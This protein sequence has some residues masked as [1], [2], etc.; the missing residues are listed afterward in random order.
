MEMSSPWAYEPGT[1]AWHPSRDIIVTAWGIVSQDP[2][3]CLERWQAI[4][5]GDSDSRPM[6]AGA[7][8]SRDG[9]HLIAGWNVRRREAPFP[10][11]LIEIEVES[12]DFT[13][14]SGDEFGFRNLMPEVS[15]SSGDVAFLSYATPAEQ[16]PRLAL[17]PPVGEAS[18]LFENIRYLHPLWDPSGSLLLV[19]ALDRDE[20]HQLLVSREGAVV[21]RISS[22]PG[23]P[24]GWIDADHILCSSDDTL[25]RVRWKDGNTD[26]VGQPGRLIGRCKVSPARTTVACFVS[27]TAVG[28]E[29]IYRLLLH[30]LGTGQ[31][32][33]VLAKQGEEA[34]F[35]GAPCWSP[36]GTKIAYLTEGGK[37][38]A[39]LWVVSAD[40]TGV[41]MVW[42]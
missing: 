37:S 27:E 31:P 32:R 30:D 33:T 38:P 39:E 4:P 20:G 35:L 3:A 41:N 2:F 34:R 40:G 7:T 15:H 17:L 9:R 11:Y 42:P 14:L 36:D 21:E 23:H 1:L 6:F 26:V 25:Y 28:E 16:F 8:W 13:L 18:V 19:A 10:T 24:V 5:P 22:M 29:S 12:G